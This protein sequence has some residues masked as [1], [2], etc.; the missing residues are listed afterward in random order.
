MKD[1]Q[2][3]SIDLL[4]PLH[5]HIDLSDR[6]L[7]TDFGLDDHVL[8]RLMDDVMLIEFCDLESGEDGSE[9]VLRGGIAIPVNQ[10][11]NM[12]RKGKV[13]LKGPNVSYTNVGEIVL[14]PANM[15]IQVSNVDVEG[16]GKIK[17]GLFLNEQ[18]MFGICYKK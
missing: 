6:N 8:S 7:P 4:K 2:P 3:A 16:F 14:F 9:F 10:V 1:Q 18:R 5:S 13:I 12:W 17:K 11:H 15:G